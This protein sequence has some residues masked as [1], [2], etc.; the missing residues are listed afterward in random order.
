MWELTIW[1]F[2]KC[3]DNQ[4]V[5]LVE[6]KFVYNENRGWKKLSNSLLKAYSSFVKLQSQWNESI[7][8]ESKE[9]L[10]SLKPIKMRKEKEL[11]LKA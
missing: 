2:I 10:K 11:Q 1:V 3:R 9:Y 8:K 5:W 4:F 7:F 6:V